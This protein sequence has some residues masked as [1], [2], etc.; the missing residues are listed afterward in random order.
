MGKAQDIVR[1]PE[2]KEPHWS[3][4]STGTVNSSMRP[5]AQELIGY[6]KILSKVNAVCRFTVSVDDNHWARQALEHFHGC[7]NAATLR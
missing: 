4:S 1:N 6:L 5:L 7:C 3:L 2:R